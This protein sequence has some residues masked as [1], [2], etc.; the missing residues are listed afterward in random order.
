M[1][2]VIVWKVEPNEIKISSVVYLTIQNTEIMKFIT[3]LNLILPLGSNCF[4]NF[5]LDIIYIYW[6]LQ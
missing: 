2:V 6:Y 1:A 4:L 5:T 3:I